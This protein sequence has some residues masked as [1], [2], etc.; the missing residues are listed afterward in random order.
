L[1]LSIYRGPAPIFVVAG[2]LAPGLVLFWF[3]AEKPTI[4]ALFARASSAAVGVA[5]TLANALYMAS[6]SCKGDALCGLNVCN[7]GFVEVLAFIAILVV[8][9]RVSARDRSDQP[10][11]NDGSG[12]SM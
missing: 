4:A 8:V 6:P 9:R 3:V 12:P 5:A 10:S 2:A 7:A 1:T 11:A